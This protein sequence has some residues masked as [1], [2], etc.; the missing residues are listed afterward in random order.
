[1]KIKLLVC[2]LIFLFVMPLTAAPPKGKSSNMALKI[3][4]TTW[5]DAN[6]ILMFVTNHGNFG[7]DLSDYFGND[8]GTFYPYAGDPDPISNSEALA[9]RSPL[10][11][12]GLWCGA[13]DSASQSIRVIVAEYNDE[14]V[15]GPMVGGSF[16]TD[17]AHFRTYKLTKSTLPTDQEYID[18]MTYAV[19]YGA[20]TKDV[21]GTLVPDIVG[22]QMLWAVYN[23]ADPTHHINNSGETL[24]MGLEIQQTTFAFNRE[25]P[26]GHIVFLKWQVYN[27]GGNTLQNC[28]FSIWSDPDLGGAGDDLVGVDTILSL[29]YTYNANNNDQFYG[30]TPPCIGFDF[31]QG[32]LEFTGDD[33]DTARFFGSRMP[34]YRNLPA[35][36]F[37]KYING[38]DP[39]DAQETYNYMRG[40][41]KDGEPYVYNGDTLLFQ[42]SGDPVTGSGDLDI[43][44]NDRR[45]MISTGPIT[46][47]PGDSTEILAAIIVGMGGDRKSSIQVMKYYDRFAQSAYDVD[48]E[49]A[50]PPEQPIVTIGELDGEIALMWTDTSE[51]VSGDY[52]FQ[53]YSIFQGVASSGP[54]TL[55]GN[56]DVIDG[57]AQILDEVLDPLTGALEIRATK[58][59]I[60]NGLK[61]YFVVDE[62]YLIGGPLRNITEYYFRVEAYSYNPVETPLTLT[63]ANQSPIVVHPQEEMADEEYQGDPGDMFNE[64]A[65]TVT[66]AGTSG[67]RVWV[68]VI[69]PSIFTGHDYRVVFQDSLAFMVDTTYD[70]EYPGDIAHASID[71]VNI[72]WHL[73]DA[74]TG[75]RLIA[76]QYN[77][78]GDNDY[79]TAADDGTQLGFIV[80][81][82]GPSPG[83]ISFQVVANNAGV[84]DPPEAGAAEWRH[85]PV[86]T[87]PSDGSNL[88]PTAA[89]QSTGGGL[90]LFHTGDNTS[91]TETG[92]RPTYENFLA[93][94]HRD[95][96]ARIAQI[97]AYE[98]EMRFTGSPASPGVN[99]SWAWEWATDGSAYWVPFEVWR[100]GSGTE[101]D[102]SD[103]VRMYPYIYGDG[104]DAAYNMSAWGPTEDGTCGP[105]GCEHSVSG[106]SNDPYMDWIYWKLPG[107][108]TPGE[109]GY[110][111][112]EADMTSDPENHVDDA[113]SVMGRTVLVN[114]NGHTGA[115]EGDT[116]TNPPVFNMDMPEEGTVFRL[117]TA[118]PNSPGDTFSFNAPAPVQVAK[119]EDVLEKIKAVPNPF[120][121]YDNYDLSPGSKRLAFHHLPEVCTINIYN[122]GGDLVK[123]IAKEDDGSAI[124][125]WNLLTDRNLPVA[126]GIYIYVVDAPGFG[127]KIGKVAIFTEAEVLKIF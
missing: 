121:L 116:L 122:L 83:F 124:A 55:I 38:T 114:W 119:T 54:W 62:D 47:R 79:F 109:A 58:L 6:K 9:V 32:P 27:K 78:S 86:P 66:H 70:P 117:V 113:S 88:R 25:D 36:S 2:L 127:T 11:A 120:Y 59:G 102:P 19:N 31:F 33:A 123:S 46:F 75:Q 26:L 76:N 16:V 96:P 77:Q 71:S 118:N 13:I 108:V 30:S 49:V 126:S 110:L 67:G 103:D 3:D 85:F 107:D 10:Y 72:I 29:G 44:P 92:T 12:A 15:P 28:Y 43:A 23:D 84:I 37:N 105:G 18:Y 93:R 57:T 51:V 40:R 106:G 45:M 89:Q 63:S 20:P 101:D 74:T 64:A 81:V 125:Y 94:V 8:Y 4:N 1:M 73:D 111:A 5:I 97:G 34:Q 22:D 87:D 112:Y 48:F 100:I 95:D 104:A 65:G 24:P 82:A 56:Y 17:S 14:Y 61:R 52:P 99:G 50:Q 42:T 69:D 53:G 68:E 39:D 35:A 21:G 91:A 115:E 80:R 90:W 98:F 7:R 41:K 60:D